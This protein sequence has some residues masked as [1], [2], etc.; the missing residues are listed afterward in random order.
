MQS[1]EMNRRRQPYIND[2]VRDPNGH[3]ST[4]DNA[5]VPSDRANTDAT[6]LPSNR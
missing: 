4:Y 3:A 6:T 2:S 5:G 1:T